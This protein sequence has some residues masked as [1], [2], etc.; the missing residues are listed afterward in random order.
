MQ[1]LFYESADTAYC[2]FT[3]LFL[4]VFSCAGGFAEGYG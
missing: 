4:R 1:E 3:N 2:G